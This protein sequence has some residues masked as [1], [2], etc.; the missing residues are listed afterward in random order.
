MKKILIALCISVAIFAANT[1]NAA[2]FFGFEIKIDFETGLK[3]WNGDKNQTECEGKGLCRLTISGGTSTLSI[4][5]LE[6]GNLA[7]VIK[8]SE[9]DSERVQK[10]MVKGA[11]FIGKDIELDAR[12][13]S[14]LARHGADLEVIKAGTYKSTESNEL[15]TIFD[16]RIK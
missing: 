15:N 8:N 9:L 14:A 6:N 13:I 4:A 16:L 2:G 5:R 10:L 12:T 11:I 1:S 7:L 3:S